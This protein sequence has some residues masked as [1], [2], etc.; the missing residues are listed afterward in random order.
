[1]PSHQPTLSTRTPK[2][3]LPIQYSQHN[4]SWTRKK[5]FD[6]AAFHKRDISPGRWHHWLHSPP[7]GHSRT[8]LSRLGQVTGSGFGA[9]ALKSR[10]GK[11]L[12]NLLG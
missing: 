1:M 2:D 10:L 5:L 9:R 4:S 3:L 12:H 7:V 6:V 11:F 8:L